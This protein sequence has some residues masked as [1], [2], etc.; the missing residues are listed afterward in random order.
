[1]I[2]VA[3]SAAMVIAV[4]PVLT[5][6]GAAVFSGVAMRAVVTRRPRHGRR[7]PSAWRVRNGG[8]RR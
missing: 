5:R 7:W 6:I 3:A 4:L 2:F 8:Q 1:M